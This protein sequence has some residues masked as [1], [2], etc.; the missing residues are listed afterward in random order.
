MRDKFIERVK[1]S[2]ALDYASASADR[3]GATLDMAGFDG[4]AAIV[5]F[6]TIAAGAV[7][8]VKMQYGDESDLSDAVDVTGL[9]ISVAADDDD[10]VFILDLFRP[11]KRYVRLVVDK[12]AANNTAEMAL[13]QQYDA[14]NRPV[15]NDVADEVTTDSVVGV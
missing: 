4:V 7:T 12:D 2:T 11:T 5:K 8:S 3:N 13:Y 10:Q 14:R 6:G 9:S 15:T 1:V